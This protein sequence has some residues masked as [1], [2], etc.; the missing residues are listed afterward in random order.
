M[1]K[2]VNTDEE[3]F[4]IF[5]TAWNMSMKFTEK[6]CLIIVILKVTQK[7]G[8]PFPLESTVLK[9]PQ[10]GFKLTSL[11]LYRVTMWE[12][13]FY[14]FWIITLYNNSFKIK[15]LGK[16]HL[17]FVVKEKDVHLRFFLTPQ[18]KQNQNMVVSLTDISD[19]FTDIRLKVHVSF[20][21]LL[22]SEMAL[23]A[24]W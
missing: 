4:H 5:Q 9:K 19:L 21:L 13:W 15:C 3:N 22:I 14:I 10:G 8:F 18:A 16:L 2:I 6:V 17:Q 11:S 12:N 24:F 1:T 7:Q 23:T 20:D